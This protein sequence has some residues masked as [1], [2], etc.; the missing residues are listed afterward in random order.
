MIDGA[1]RK[2]KNVAVEND[3]VKEVNIFL[4]QSLTKDR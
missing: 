4:R 2:E 1:W 3:D